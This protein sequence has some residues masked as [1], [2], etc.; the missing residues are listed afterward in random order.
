MWPV[1]YPT[2]SPDPVDEVC[3]RTDFWVRDTLGPK[4]DKEGDLLRLAQSSDTCLCVTRARSL[5]NLVGRRGEEGKEEE[6]ED[7]SL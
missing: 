3:S 4:T 1:R 6:E 2:W 5:I 7:S